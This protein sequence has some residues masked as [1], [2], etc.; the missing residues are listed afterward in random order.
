MMVDDDKRAEPEAFTERHR[1]SLVWIVPL[2]A[3]IVAGWLG[4]RALADRGPLIELTMRTANGVEVDKTVVRH[5]QIELGSVT[6]M[7]PSSD[8]THVTLSIRMNHFAK[9]LLNAD[10]KFWVVRP[11]ATLQG[12]SGL[13]TLVSGSYIEMQPGQGAPARHFTALEDPPVVTADVPGTEYLLDGQTLGS[14][15]QGAPVSY[16]GIT[17]GEVMGYTLSER[18]GSVAVRVFVHAPHDKLVMEGTHFWN[19]SG[20][21]ADLTSE[22]V[23]VSMESVLSVL[24]G[25]V[26]F[27][28]PPGIVRGDAAAAETHFVLYGDELQARNSLYTRR[29]P[30]L[31]HLAGGARGL[32]TGAPVFMEGI[33]V[34]DVTDLHMEYDT[35]T[36]QLSIPVTIE[37]EPQRIQILHNTAPT[38]SGF[39]QR[40]YD[41]F[42]AFVSHGL[43]ATLAP[44]SLITGQKYIALDFVHDGPPAKLIQGGALPEI[45]VVEASDIDAIMQTAKQLLASLQGTAQALDKA[46]NGPQMKRSLQSLDRA[47]ANL[48]EV[49]HTANVKAGPLLDSL[50]DTSASADRALKEAES[51]LSTTDAALSGSGNDG[52]LAGTLAELKQAAQAIKSLA[53]ELQRHPSSLVWG[54]DTEGG[55]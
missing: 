54:K 52:N 38:S 40:A 8:L 30:F 15:T 6:A 5:N 50:H 26:A 31:L 29:V 10:T 22:G 27:D 46:V 4:F 39:E 37:I 49:T 9:D 19:A 23:H 1:I 43:R 13:N 28:V 17:V 35:R 44:G 25:G 24:G 2:V 20:V 3:I 47:L 7:K 21:T 16:H 53:D 12:I 51:T 34:G 48:D 42:A 14:I 41:A 55:K 36:S 11:R 18:D 33:R 32:S 45:P